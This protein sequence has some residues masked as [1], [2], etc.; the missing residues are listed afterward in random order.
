MPKSETLEIEEYLQDVSEQKHTGAAWQGEAALPGLDFSVPLIPREYQSALVTFESPLMEYIRNLREK[1]ISISSELSFISGIYSLTGGDVIRI[2]DEKEGDKV[3]E[4]LFRVL[5]PLVQNSR[6]SPASDTQA[7]ATSD[8][9]IRQILNR[10]FLVIFSNFSQ[11]QAAIIQGIIYDIERQGVHLPIQSAHDFTTISQQYQPVVQN[12]AIIIRNMFRHLFP[13]YAPPDNIHILE[14]CFL[15]LLD[16]IQ[17]NFQSFLNNDEQLLRMLSRVKVAQDELLNVQD[18][19]L[20]ELLARMEQIQNYI[21][22]I[23]NQRWRDGILNDI[24]STFFYH[25]RFI[26]YLENKGKISHKRRYFMASLEHLLNN[27]EDFYH[28]TLI[29]QVEILV[30]E[31]REVDAQGAPFIEANIRFGRIRAVF[32]EIFDEDK[33]SVL[34][35]MIVSDGTDESA[36]TTPP[37][38]E[39]ENMHEELIHKHQDNPEFLTYINRLWENLDNLQ[40]LLISEIFTK[41]KDPL[42]KMLNIYCQELF[43]FHGCFSTYTI[44]TFTDKKLVLDRL[45]AFITLYDRALK[46][47]S[48]KVLERL[49]SL[50]QQVYAFRDRAGDFNLLY[51]GILAIDLRSE[52]NYFQ[53]ELY[54]PS[55]VKELATRLSEIHER[56]MQALQPQFRKQANIASD[57]FYTNEKNHRLYTDEIAKTAS[58]LAEQRELL[59]YC[60]SRKLFTG[61]Q[62]DEDDFAHFFHEVIDMYEHVINRLQLK[63]LDPLDNIVELQS[64]RELAQFELTYERYTEVVKYKALS[65]AWH[66]IKKKEQR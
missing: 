60:G 23:Y 50:S 42:T 46:N 33:F 47:F 22:D 21:H 62:F 40:E 56:Y 18:Q 43:W 38:D 10:A 30:E 44:D 63:F 9:E 32:Q 17:Q 64:L 66:M 39:L 1:V 12:Q 14:L 6:T 34:S 2:L 4:K 5:Y 36:D 54:T 27:Y 26:A 28:E 8:A 20:S 53:F 11:M 48:E 65:K 58:Y 25:A 31:Y 41:W 49:E 35:E 57:E 52:E 24:I 51:T 13:Q 3:K 19:Q 37:I 29:P 16:Q 59:M 55:Q 7:P 15:G 45:E 61:P